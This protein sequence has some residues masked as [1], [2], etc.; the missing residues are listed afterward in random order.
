LF[1]NWTPQEMV[2]GLARAK[3]KKV[4]DIIC[5]DVACNV[6]TEDSIILGAD[7]TVVIPDGESWQ[8]L[9]KPK[10]EQDAKF[11]IQTLRNNKH[12]VYTGISVIINGRMPS[13]AQGYGRVRQYAPTIINDYDISTVTFGN[14]TDE[15]IDRYI[16][17]GTVM[18]KAVYAIQDIGEEFGI[19]VE[20][21]VSNV[22]GLPMERLV[23]HFDK[24]GI[25]YDRDWEEK[26]NFK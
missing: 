25:E 5:R 13:S 2:M 10:S 22:I 24:V 18:D 7:T 20:G 26:L 3:V 19:T 11:M 4:W 23:Q 16:A 17:T 6:Y 1:P 8:S 21:S 14:F 12:Q 9:G 15:T